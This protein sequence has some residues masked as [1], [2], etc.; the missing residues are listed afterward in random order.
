MSSTF[1]IDFVGIGAPKCGTTWLGHMLEV[2][3][4]LC[5]SEPKQVHFFNDVLAINSFLKPQF[6]KGL[7]WYRQFFNHC[8]PAKL[9][10]EITPRYSVDPEAALRIRE[11]NPDIEI[12]YCVRNPV[13]RIWSQFQFTTHFARNESRPIMEAL[14]KEPEYI[15]MSRFY[16][17]LSIYRRLFSD[18]QIFILW[19]D[20]IVHRPGE[21]LQDIYSFLG[22]DPFFRPHKMYK[23]SNAARMSR[24]VH[25]QKWIRTF[26]FY[27]AK[28][29]FSGV[30]KKLKMAGL[31]EFVTRI[32][33][34]YL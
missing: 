5:M 27:F 29:G 11:H 21:L 3:P 7:K 25:L 23:K 15:S 8:S 10:G 4:Q 32:N 33:S 12:I 1:K 30:I 18:S 20:D 31:N 28:F 26:T 14:L 13:D 9:K 22:V 19:F 24:F 34:K 6:H 16:K 17:N 2:H